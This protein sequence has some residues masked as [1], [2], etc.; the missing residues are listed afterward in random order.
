MKPERIDGTGGRWR[1]GIEW[2]GGDEIKIEW[3]NGSGSEV[4]VEWANWSVLRFT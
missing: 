1:S 2:K 3:L 4:A